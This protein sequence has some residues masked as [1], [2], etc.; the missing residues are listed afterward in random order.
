M[1][2]KLLLIAACL[3]CAAPAAAHNRSISFSQWQW[4]DTHI[5]VSVIASARD[6]TLLE[7]ATDIRRSAVL[8]AQHA[9]QYLR[10]TDSLSGTPCKADRPFTPT[11]ARAGFVRIAAR[12][13][14]PPETTA[15]ALE[16]DM[17]FDLIPTHTHLARFRTAQDA[18]NPAGTETMLT[19]T[20]RRFRFDPTQSP[21]EA[22]G[23]F[24]TL[25]DY[26]GLG[27]A[28]IL[29]GYDHLAF[30]LAL[31]LLA[32]TPRRILIMVT[33]FT[34][35]HSLTLALAALGLVAANAVFV[36]AVIGLSIAVVAA[37]SF[38]ARR[39]LMALTGFVLVPLLYV[40]AGIGAATGGAMPLGA[41]GGLMLF[42]L[43]YGLAVRNLGDARAFAPAMTFIFGLFHGFGF[44]GILRDVGLPEG[45]ALTGL[46]GFNLGVE[47]GQILII[48]ALWGALWVALRIP[49]TPF[50]KRLEARFGLRFIEFPN[51]D[52][53]RHAAACLLVGLGSFW[54]VQRA[55]F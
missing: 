20:Q 17:L 37:E 46:L 8:L 19:D 44:A 3:L 47:V 23:M 26:F 40:L 41:W 34:L 51:V 29:T 32:Q 12:Y 7:G 5:E 22:R 33:G 42:C 49:T 35:G 25:A 2:L 1:R 14:C 50:G 54:F 28:H 18:A 55:V 45:Y 10:I 6:A 53:Y 30:L 36:E 48:A 21:D 43:C 4:H 15:I 39:G 31:L 52:F 27:V 16:N 9:R 38:L 24:G 11:P 13:V